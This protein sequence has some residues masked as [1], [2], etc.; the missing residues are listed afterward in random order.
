[1]IA[2]VDSSKQSTLYV[3]TDRRAVPDQARRHGD[4][5]TIAFTQWNETFE[6][7]RP[8]GAVDIDKLKAG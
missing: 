7:R 4:K 3:S 1:M 6:S 2:L 5:G 8:P